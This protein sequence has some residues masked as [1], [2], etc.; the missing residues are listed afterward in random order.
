MAN[1]DG[2]AIVNRQ[3]NNIA[4][5]D[6]TEYV[7]D[8]RIDGTPEND[9]IS[10]SDPATRVRQV[11]GYVGGTYQY[12]GTRTDR[13]TGEDDLFGFGGDDYIDGKH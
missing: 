2:N 11:Y 12:I 13:A 3:F 5:N 6:T 4:T 7:I 9:Y 1:F 10:G 8:I